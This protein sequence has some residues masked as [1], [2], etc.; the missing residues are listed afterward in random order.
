MR[1]ALIGLILAA[2]VLTPIAAQAQEDYGRTG[3]QARSDGN[4]AARTEQRQARIEARQEQRQEQRQQRQEQR[5]QRV[6]RVAQPAPAPVV[7][8][9]RQQR[10]E[11]RQQRQERRVDTNREGSAYPSAWQG[12]PNDPARRRYERLERRN[13]YVHGTREQ[14]EVVREEFQDRGRRVPQEWREDRREERFE[15]RR[16]RRRDWRR[17]WNRDQW[18]NDRRYDW[19]S[20]RYRN[21]DLFSGWRYNAPYRGH[22]YSRF[23]IGFFLEPLFYSRNYWLNDPW[24]YR[25]PYAPAG[26]QW[27]RYY[28]DVLLVDVYTGEVIDVIYDF[29]W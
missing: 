21:R 23:S 19:Q 28:D 1:K 24:Q 12:D 9:A 20:W 15:D 25:L 8:E 2:T 3:R 18:R 27:I 6:E 17:E 10:Q 4:R 11:Y 29:F 16:D 26:T 13:Q 22:R 7:Q 5:Q 14:R